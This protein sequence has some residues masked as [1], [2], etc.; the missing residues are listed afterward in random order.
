[1]KKGTIYLIPSVIAPDTQ[2]QVIP[3]Q[4]KEI[5]SSTNYFI[6]ETV[7]ESRRYISS[8]KLGIDISTLHFEKVDKN[9]D[10][11]EAEKYL[12]PALEGHSIGVLSDAGCPG[13]ADPGA[14]VASIAH[15]LGL[16]VIPLVGPSSIMLALMASGMNGQSFAFNGY[17]PIDAK[18]A[19]KKII[20]HEKLSG[21]SNQTQI[22]IETPYRSD[23]TFELLV[24][25]LSS[26][27]LL[28]IARDIT[29]TN[30]LILTKPVN[31]WKKDKIA[32]G[33][34]PAVFLFHTL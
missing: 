17:L 31:Q 15:K 2:N 30:E 28:C 14:L 34:E 1:M 8:L 22:F 16:R 10:T 9:T 11:I 32:I 23:R 13:I 7:R 18:E 25:T 21:T 20:E 26:H 29:G 4:V 33:K 27:T 3:N 24:K 5:I 19:S 6:A 12:K